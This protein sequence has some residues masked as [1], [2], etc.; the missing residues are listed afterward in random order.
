MLEVF[1]ALFGLLNLLTTWRFCVVAIIGA[2][3]A[4]FLFFQVQNPIL[5]LSAAITLL[6]VFSW[7]GYRWQRTAEA[8]WRQ[9]SN[10]RWRGP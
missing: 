3:A 4:L 9:S 1:D 10:N 7:L 2:V 6:V 5:G 8:R